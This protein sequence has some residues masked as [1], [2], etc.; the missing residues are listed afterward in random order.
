ME[1]FSNEI[2]KVAL[3]NQNNERKRRWVSHTVYIIITGCV[4]G[5][6]QKLP[7]IG[8]FYVPSKSCV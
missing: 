7:Q 2:G 6:G 3:N 1:R 8:R 4:K 5:G